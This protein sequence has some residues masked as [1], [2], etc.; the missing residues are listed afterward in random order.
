[1]RQRGLGNSSAQLQTK[2]SE[3]HSET[4]LRQSAHYLADCDA[5]REAST[6]KLVIMPKFQ[7]VPKQ[8]EVPGSKWLLSIYC[9]DVMQRLDEV[10]AS[11]TSIFGSV[12]KMDSTKKVHDFV[13]AYIHTGHSR[14][15]LSLNPINKLL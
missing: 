7:R 10:K 12:L 1:M 15:V 5:Y 9:Q 3:E 14:S 4:W 2:I 8:P 6:K 11:I 13:Y